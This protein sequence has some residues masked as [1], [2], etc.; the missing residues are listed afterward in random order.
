MIRKDVTY[1]IKDFAMIKVKNNLKYTK[2]LEII[3]ILQENL[4][5]LLLAFDIKIYKI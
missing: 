2:K 5:Q 4:E 3:V 1:I